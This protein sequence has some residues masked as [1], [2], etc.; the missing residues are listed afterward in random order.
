VP[1]GVPAAVV[2]LVFLFRIVERSPRAITNAFSQQA[3]YKRDLHAA[4]W[5]PMLLIATMLLVRRAFGIDGGP[6]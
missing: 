2:V 3:A 1:V 5:L 4:I 6:T